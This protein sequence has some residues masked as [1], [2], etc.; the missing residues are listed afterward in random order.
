MGSEMCIRDRSWCRG[1]TD[2]GL[3]H[4]VDHAYELEALSLRGC[5]QI[6]DIF[7]N[8]HSNT[9]VKVHGRRLEDST[10]RVLPK[11]WTSG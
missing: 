1:V 11:G 8:G 10:L 5:A 2:D 6:T 3:G 7:L 9:K 4:L